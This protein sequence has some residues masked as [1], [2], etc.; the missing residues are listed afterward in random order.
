MLFTKMN[1]NF[2]YYFFDYLLTSEHQ[3]TTNYS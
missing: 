2:I 1:C 3:K